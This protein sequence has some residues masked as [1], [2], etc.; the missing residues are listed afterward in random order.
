M[1]QITK[2][3]QNNNKKQANKNPPVYLNN[4]LINTNGKSPKK[5]IRYSG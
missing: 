2:T 5:I 1:L 3:K 4:N